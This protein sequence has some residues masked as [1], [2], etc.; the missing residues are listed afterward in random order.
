MIHAATIR[1]M[2][3]RYASFL[4]AEAI[5]RIFVSRACWFSLIASLFWLP[6][7]AAELDG[8]QL[9]DT[10]QV[11]GKTLHLN[12]FGRRTYS[13]LRIHIYAA[14]LYL[15]RLSTDADEILASPETKLLNI[16]FEHNVSADDA[17]EAWRKG[18]ENNCR[19]SCHLDPED[20]AKFL[21]SVPA[22]NVGDN[23]SLLFTQNGAT[24]TV[25]GHQIGIISQPL[26]AE[27]ML[28]TFLGPVPASLRLKQ[29][30]LRGHG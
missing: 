25:N 11:E 12:G 8:M 16:R 23:Y 5:A 19:A 24:V 17:R 29:E 21:A 7:Q 6:A 18:L 20:V 30:L 26:F 1:P 4:P 13:L 10:V 27:A 22:M 3:G 14:D 15:E 9:P 2:C 28:A